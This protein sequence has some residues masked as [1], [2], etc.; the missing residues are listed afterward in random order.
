MLLHHPLERHAA[1]SPRAEAVV[2][3]SRRLSYA[4]L[5]VLANRFAQVLRS[6]GLGRG[7]RVVVHLPN[8][9]EAVGA[10][11]GVLK[12]GGVFVPVDPQVRP[13]KLAFL[14]ADSGARFLL[15]ADPEALAVVPRCPSLAA[16]LTVG[17]AGASTSSSRASPT[18]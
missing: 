16:V 3:G 8:S 17:D 7:D 15:T 9:V 5:E 14:L 12:A 1:A 6:R 13:R 11:F 4:E 18:A 2:C 10:L